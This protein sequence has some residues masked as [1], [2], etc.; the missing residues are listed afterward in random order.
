MF[1]SSKITEGSKKHVNGPFGPSNQ[2]Q[3]WW[4]VQQCWAAQ[5]LT[6]GLPI[7]AQTRSVLLQVRPILDTQMWSILTPL[8]MAPPAQKVWTRNP[9]LRDVQ[10]IPLQAN[11]MNGN[12]SI[13]VPWPWRTIKPRNFQYSCLIWRNF[14]I[15]SPNYIRHPSHVGFTHETFCFCS[16]FLL[17]KE[18]YK[19]LNSKHSL[20]A[21]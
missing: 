16:L 8:L 15:S 17:S 2:A 12:L 11:I 6:W 5:C 20:L 3:I 1:K 13:Q 21:R 14:Q 10:L 9:L 4:T 7:V 18:L 19:D